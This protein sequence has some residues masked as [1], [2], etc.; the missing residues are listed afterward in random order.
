[1][2]HVIVADLGMGNLRSVA[3]ALERAGASVTVSDQPSVISAA[4]RLVVPGQG[5]FQDC[6]RAMQKGF[7]DAVR[8]FVAT[9]R[10]Y[11]GLC[12]GMQILFDG[13]EE[14][15]GEKGLGFF[16]G[17]VVRFKPGVQLGEG[18]VRKIPHM[19][20]NQV[21]GN[22]AFLQ[23]QDWFYFVHSFHC[24]PKDQSVTI[25]TSE[26]GERICAAVAKENVVACQFHPEKSQ[27]AGAR[28]LENFVSKSWSM[29]S[30]RWS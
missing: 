11:L 2:S 14:A 27:H 26:Y 15:P 6:A 21:D 16:E 7:G 4:E 3:H 23:P 22:H 19:G 10:P 8:T 9:G 25:G 12:L 17:E 29:E 1:M 24:V 13:S 30:K 18:R 5:H 20:W 28:L